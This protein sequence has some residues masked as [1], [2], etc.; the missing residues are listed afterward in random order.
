MVSRIKN[1]AMII[2]MR[3]NWG[4]FYYG[5]TY[6]LFEGINVGNFIQCTVMVII[7]RLDK[8]NMECFRIKPLLNQTY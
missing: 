2:K 4:D 7:L 5:C 6:C 3:P 1:M 8:N